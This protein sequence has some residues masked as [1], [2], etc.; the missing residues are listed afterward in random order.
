MTE[1]SLA[2]LNRFLSHRT[3]TYEVSMVQ[4]FPEV[5]SPRIYHQ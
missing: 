3:A 1:L 2:F 5:I 4:K